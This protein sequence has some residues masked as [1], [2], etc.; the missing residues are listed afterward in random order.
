MIETQE[1][2]VSVLKPMLAW[3]NSLTRGFAETEA[4]DAGKR[5][6]SKALK[7]NKAMKKGVSAKAAEV[8]PMQRKAQRKAIPMPDQPGPDGWSD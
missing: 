1:E 4:R 7:K 3:S 8:I 5:A 6:K 2:H